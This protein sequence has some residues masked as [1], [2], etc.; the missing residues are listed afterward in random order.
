VEGKGFARGEREERA[1]GGRREQEEEVGGEGITRMQHTEGRRGRVG[2]AL[3]VAVASGWCA[4]EWNGRGRGEED[5]HGMVD[6]CVW[7]AEGSEA[8]APWRGE[9]WAREK[10]G[11]RGDAVV[12]VAPRWWTGGQPPKN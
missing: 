11:Q 10:C 1:R 8:C 5:A 3:V 2:C 12:V 6:W 7:R 9:I 4:H